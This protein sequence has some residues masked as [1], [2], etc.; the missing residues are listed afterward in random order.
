[1]PA[2]SLTAA[3]AA[4]QAQH[5]SDKG[6]GDQVSAKAEELREARTPDGPKGIGQDLSD[7]IHT[8]KPK[9][10]DQD[11]S[12]PSGDQGSDDPGDQGSDHSGDKGIG[13]QVS[14]KAQE[15]REARTD[16]GPKGI[17]KDLSDFI[18]TLKPK[19]TDQDESHPS[20]DQGSD[21]SGDQGSDDHGDKGI[22]DQ[23]SAKAQELREARTDDG[24]KGIGKDLSDF[25][26]TIKPTTDS[27]V[28]TDHTA[29]VSGEN[30]DG[31]AILASQTTGAES[32]SLP[33]AAEKGIATAASHNASSKA[34]NHSPVFQTDLI[35]SD[36]VTLPDAAGDGI[37]TAASHNGS[38][39]ADHSPVFGKDSSTEDDSAASPELAM[40]GFSA[41]AAA[42]AYYYAMP[43][44]AFDQWKEDQKRRD[45]RP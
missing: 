18:H 25:I 38:S 28:D 23:V 24:P 42:M 33:E 27:D 36:S 3:T 11:E 15:L 40:N 9:S 30:P 41:L 17:G 20:G 45:G 13:D 32:P 31:S 21:D 10:T 2:A 14:A 44:N 1:L 43:T 19:S 7:F 6:I 8:L 16:D 4:S 35:G 12:H 22:G 39:E 29:P 37:A 34:P 5:D 26:Q